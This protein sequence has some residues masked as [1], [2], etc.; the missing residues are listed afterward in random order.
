MK[1]LAELIF[2]IVAATVQKKQFT[3]AVTAASPTAT[4]MARATTLSPNDSPRLKVELNMFSGKE[5]NLDKWH[6]VQSSQAKINGFAEKM[7]A[8]DEIRVGAKDFN[9]QGIDSLRA[10]CASKARVTLITTCK[11]TAL[12]VVQ[13]TDSPSAA[14]L[15][16]YRAC[17]VKRKPA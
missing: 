1:Q 14:W 2:V 5:T 12:K 7:V 9:I 4:G 15:Q 11:D 17:G 10:K 13:S 8:T 16:R 3:A 6:K